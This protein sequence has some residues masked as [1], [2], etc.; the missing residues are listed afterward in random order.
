MSIGSTLP[1]QAYTRE[2][3][4]V[5]FNWLQTQPE[6]IRK[7]A[8]S[9]DALVGLYMRA[10]RFGQSEAISTQ[11]FVSDLKNLA[12]GLK[13]F[14]DDA[15][16]FSAP[17]PD[18]HTMQPPPNFSSTY[19]RQEFEE[20]RPERA[21]PNASAGEVAPLDARA[22][23]LNEASLEMAREIRRAMNLSSDAEA[24]NMMMSVAY[25]SLRNLLA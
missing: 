18:A 19:A 2:I 15:D 8:T 22:V 17:V 11:T 21:P 10:Q 25:K 7:L 16:G 6:S 1:P 12:E 4:A 24:A 9:P 20:P 14:D 23:R 3:L 13:Q 5:A